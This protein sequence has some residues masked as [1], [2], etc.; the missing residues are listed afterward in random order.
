[1]A[2]CTHTHCF[3]AGIS[4]VCP[5]CGMTQQARPYD[6]V[7]EREADEREERRSIAAEA[8]WQAVQGE[9]YGSY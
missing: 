9:E 3:W 2:D 1:M 6:P 8:H 5:K 4:R 7:R